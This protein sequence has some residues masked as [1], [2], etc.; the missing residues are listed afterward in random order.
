MLR[1]LVPVV[2]VVG[3]SKSGRTTL[4]EKLIAELKGRGYRVGTIKHH[5]H[6]G[7][8]MDRP[9]TDTWRHAQAG[10]DHV[11]L[12][13]PDK[14]ASIR[15][16]DR[17]PHL[18]EMAAMMND[19]DVILT[20]GYLRTGRHR[21]EVVRAARSSEPICRPEQLLA[22]A[23]DVPLAY[24]VPQY[25][26][27]DAAGL[28]DLIEGLIRQ[29]V[30]SLATGVILAGGE[31][32][33]M[34]RDKAFLDLGGCP[35]I[36]IVADRLRQVA[37]EIIISADNVERFAPYGDRCVPDLYH[38]VGTLGGIHAGLLAASHDL[39]VIVGCDMPLLNPDVLARFVNWAA[40]A[41]LVVLRQEQGVEPLHAVY[42]K[43]CLPAIEK[44]IQTG[45][46]CA[47][48]FYND[49]RVRYVHPGEIADLDPE[50]QS[51]CN[52]NTPS[53][54]SEVVEQAAVLQ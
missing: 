6:P 28:V 47:Y 40:E 3:R 13:A 48:A 35:M 29:P 54:W 49:I 33:R 50:L 19:V 39:A 8:V 24:E 9:G 16:V 12:A 20:E 37:D 27:E 53:E 4:V 32:R 10:S 45:Q 36:A 14:V 31:S 11:V 34:G 25:G 18:H 21:I 5:S 17:E 51:F 46:R 22:L 44:T 52:V 7:F 26:L 38:G 42:R 43:S 41:D 1:S 2:N 30:P 23:T 15:F